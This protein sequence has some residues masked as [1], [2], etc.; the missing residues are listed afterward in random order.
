[1]KNST[2]IIIG[3]IVVILAVAIGTLIWFLT[4][5]SDYKITDDVKLD[6]VTITNINIE[7][8]D[9]LSTYRGVVT[10]RKDVSIEHI[11]IEAYDN[12]DNKVQFVGYVNKDLKK[13]EKVD[14]VSSIDKDITGYKKITYKVKEKN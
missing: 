3:V 12:D 8:K 10:A 14:I 2:K 4:R 13:D 11:V 1:M 7:Y 6:Q 9:N 5:K